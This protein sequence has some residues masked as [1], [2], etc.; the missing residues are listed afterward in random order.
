MNKNKKIL[1]IFG[2][3]M[4]DSFCGALARAYVGGAKSSGA[5]VR[6]IYL[7]ELDFDPIL[8]KGYKEVQELEPG[9]NK[10]R[11]DIKWAEHIVFVYPTWW[12]TMPALLKGFFD[13]VFLPRFAFKFTG[14]YS[15]EK[16]LKGRSARLLVTMDAP[17]FFYKLFLGASGVKTIKKAILLMSGV[18]PVKVTMFGSLKNSSE[19]KRKKWLQKAEKLGKKLA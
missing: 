5:E 16:L 19:A 3:P 4:R 15:W 12:G 14:K 18:S 7:G 9:L 10:A 11:E 13:R 1:L 2:H 17:P 6:E 8:H